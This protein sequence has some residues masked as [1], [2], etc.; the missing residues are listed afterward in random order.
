MNE[1]NQAVPLG[2]PSIFGMF[3]CK[4]HGQGPSVMPSGGCMEC[5]QHAKPEQLPEETEDRA[6]I[7]R[8]RITRRLGVLSVPPRYE[9]ARFAGWVGDT[10]AQAAA[11]QAMREVAVGANRLGLICTGGVGTGKTWL[12]YALATEY[13]KAD[14][15]SAQVVRSKRV[16]DQWMDAAHGRKSAVVDGYARVGLLVLDDVGASFNTSHELVVLEELVQERYD[17]RRPTVMTTNLEAGALEPIIGGR[18]LDRF[19]HGLNYQ[20]RQ[21]VFDWK[22]RRPGQRD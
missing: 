7:L 20:V 12:A 16:V 13:I 3:E 1:G 2:V 14:L 22:S 8:A 6:R 11:L 5:M 15:G 17:Q 18:A 10:D 21:V 4:I 9:G 19:R